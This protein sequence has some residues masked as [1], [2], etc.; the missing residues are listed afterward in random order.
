LERTFKDTLAM[1]EDHELVLD[2]VRYTWSGS[3]RGW[4]DADRFTTPASAIQSR[5]NRKFINERAADVVSRLNRTKIDRFYDTLSAMGA[6]G[7]ELMAVFGDDPDRLPRA[8]ADPI[9]RVATKLPSAA[10]TPFNSRFVRDWFFSELL[11]NPRVIT[12]LPLEVSVVGCDPFEP[13]DF[14]DFLKRHDVIPRPVDDDSKVVVIGR[15]GWREAEIDDLIDLRVG[16][17]LKIY[18][19]EMFLV[20]MAIGQDP[21]YGTPVVLEAFKAGHPGL[22]FVSR[23]WSGWVTTFVQADRRSPSV[24]RLFGSASVE[25]SP[26]HLLGYHVG[27]TGEEVTTRRRLLR[28]AFTGDLPITGSLDYMAKWGE[29]SSPQRLKQIAENIAAYCRV[30]R[31]RMNPSE[32]AIEDWESDLEWLREEFYHGHFT[33][34]WPGIYA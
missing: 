18:S 31:S 23:G 3:S 24:R 34:H 22:D 13:Q 10:H 28:R 15:K 26:L 12:P 20:F 19:Q 30:Q 8:L 16:E 17:I 27:R 6:T 25:E 14:D 11:R 2:R 21:F 32:E 1:I 7:E 5:L 33:F 4:I 9:L 29:P